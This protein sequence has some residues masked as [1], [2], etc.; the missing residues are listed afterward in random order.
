MMHDTILKPESAGA[1]LR[2]ALEHEI[3]T[4]RLA[5]GARLDEVALA[6]RFGVSR[7]PIREALMQLSTA[8][9]IEL[10]HR[11]GAIVVEL[12][13]R[14]LIDMF[15]VMAGLEGHAGHLAARRHTDEDRELLLAAHRACETAMQSGGSDRYYYENENFHQAIY[16][17]CHNSFLTEQCLSLSRR[18]KPYRRLQLH[19]RNRVQSSFQE[20]QIIVDAILCH[21]GEA[22]DQALRDHVRIQGERFGDFVASLDLLAPA[23]E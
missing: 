8:G 22:A 5:P 1:R 16:A 17:A 11:R 9:L 7:T 15:E 19:V 14:Q 18:L 6:T 21:D 3:L 10:R 2:D 4:G 12:G 23:A 13:A 20:H